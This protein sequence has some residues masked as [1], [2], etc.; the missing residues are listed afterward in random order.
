M[1][2]LN[3]V[4]MDQT[5]PVWVGD[6]AINKLKELFQESFQS[7]TKILVISD[8][9]VTN[10]HKDVLVKVL[11]EQIDWKWHTV[12]KGE[13]AKSFA[14]FEQCISFALE[15]QLDRKSC[16]LAFGGGATGDLAGYVAASFMRGIPFIQI[17]TTILAHDSAVGGKVAIN[18]PLG[19]NMVGHFYQPKAVVYDT[20][21]LRTLPAQEIRSGFAEVIKHALIQDASFLEDLMTNLQDFQ[22]MDEQYLQ[23]CLIRGIEIKANIVAVD[24]KEHGIRAFLNFGH[25]YGHA[26]EAKM[27]YGNITH[28]EAVMIGM[29]YA[30]YLSKKYFKLTLDLHKFQNWI[31]SLGYQL[32]I[33][34]SISFEDL[35]N[36][37]KRDK[38]TIGQHVRFVLLKQIGEPVLV[39]MEEKDL[40]EADAFIRSI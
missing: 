8:E 24:E 2:S 11:P 13:Q 17:P 35:F 29:M 15:S 36:A 34:T 30:L 16:I 27:G 26:L 33:S 9:N 19:K 25:T 38:K 18:H 1:Q 40:L 5:Y 3:V 4:T 10:L 39:D 21:F 6:G 32:N 12:P 20:R 14:V 7:V 23:K 28:G 31:E 37:M 22:A